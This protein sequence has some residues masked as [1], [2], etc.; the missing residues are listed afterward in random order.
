M[1]IIKY[2]DNTKCI[3]I[4]GNLPIAPQKEII[5]VSNFVYGQMFFSFFYSHITDLLFSKAGI[6]LCFCPYFSLKIF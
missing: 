1:F 3:K 5:T 6:I 4:E 2:S